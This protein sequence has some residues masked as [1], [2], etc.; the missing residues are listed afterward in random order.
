[1]IFIFLMLTI[2]MHFYYFSIKQIKYIELIN[3]NLILSLK[4]DF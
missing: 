2:I 1:M 3:I 4:I